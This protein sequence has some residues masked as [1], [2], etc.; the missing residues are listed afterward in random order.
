MLLFYNY[1][2]SNYNNNNNNNKMMQAAVK[3]SKGN[4]SS[5]FAHL[6]ASKPVLDSHFVDI[7]KKLVTGKEQQA[8]IQASYE[9]LLQAF[10]KEKQEIQQLGSKVI[11]E[12]HMNDI[13]KNNGRLPDDI[14]Q[15]VKKRGSLVVRGVLE[16]DQA[17]QYKQDIKNYIQSHRG[18]ITGFPENQPQVWE[19]YWTP[20]QVKARANE[21]F[22]IA[23][24][25][26]S[27]LWHADP[28]TPVDFTKNV[29]YCD[30]LRIREA[31]DSNFAL[32]EHIDSGSVERWEDETYSK[33][34]QKIF[35]GQWEEYDAFDATHRV[36]AKMDLH[37]SPGGCSMLRISQGWIALSDIVK[38]G[39]HIKVC[40]LLKEQTAYYMLKPL[41]EEYINEPDLL[42]AYPGRCH[43]ISKENHSPIT[44]I[45]VSAPDVQCGDAVFWHC[46]QVHSVEPMNTMTTDSSVLYIPSTPLC[47]INSEYL[48]LQR[49]AF[50]KGCTPPD[51]PD[52]NSEQFFTDRSTLDTLTEDQKIGMGFQRFPTI[53]NESLTF[54]QLEAIKQ[55]N[56]IMGL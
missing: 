25:A 17:I 23:S 34:Y 39:G 2:K 7:K 14:A 1:I 27:Q 47:K 35:D 53:E 54:G 3:E 21:N 55:H 5:V 28:N 33:C 12:I 52:N 56:E 10:E 16:R 19:L 45:M 4:I 30:R 36:D 24:L 51:F 38:D 15:L 18:D 8:N 42:G 29:T 50:E 22:N 32:N 40:P 20:S 9:R 37:Q 49:D 13:K 6:G 46:D 41:L 43:D 44:E 48:K 26:L 31:G 11:P